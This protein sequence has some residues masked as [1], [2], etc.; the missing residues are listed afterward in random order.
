MLKLTLQF[1]L[2]MMSLYTKFA[3]NVLFPVHEKLK[4][5][6]TFE[7]L[8]YLEQ[9][10]WQEPGDI[11][12][13]Q[14]ENWQQFAEHLT[15]YNPFIKAQYN[16]AFPKSIEQLSALPIADKALIRDNFEQY[17]STKTNAPIVKTT[18]GSSGTPFKFALGKDRIS[19]DIAAKLRAT[20]WWGVDIGS[21]EAVIWG[22]NVELSGQ[23]LVKQVR[24][25]VFRTKLFPAQHLDEQGLLD[26]FNQLNNYQAEMFYG[27]PSILALLANFALKKGLEYK[28]NNLKVVF[29]TAEKLFDH[30]REVIEKVFKAPTANGYGSRDA[31]FIAHECPEGSLHISEEHVLVEIVDDEGQACPPGTLGHIV[32][33]H[34]LTQDFP[35]LR[36]KTGDMGVLSDQPCRCGRKLLSFKEVVGRSNDVLYD[37]NGGAVHGSFV[38]NLVREERAI[39]NFQLIQH[40]QTEFELKL[41]LHAHLPFEQ[42]NICRK[43]ASVLGSEAKISCQILEDIPSEATGKYKY[44]INKCL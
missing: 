31:G 40:S 37:I 18:S 35:I 9:S 21:K 33:T 38:G 43:L 32:V 34:L 41:V 39:S 27:Y 16:S 12:Q 20:R 44:I 36:Y 14:H 23:G 2:S 30:Q 6:S 4:G 7:I 42:Q 8:K 11:R 26:L 10:Q 17:L 28:P 24:D 3:A 29:C 5:H 25:S 15:Q 13:L 22:S 19:H 1:E